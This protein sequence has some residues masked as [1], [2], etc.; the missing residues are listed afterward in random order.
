MISPKNGFYKSAIFSDESV[1]REFLGVRRNFEMVSKGNFI[2]V[3]MKNLNIALVHIFV[4]IFLIYTMVFRAE[5]GKGIF[6]S[7][8]TYATIFINIA[9]FYF[10]YFFVLPK[11]VKKPSLL[12]VLLGIFTSI[13]LFILLKFFIE[14][15]FL[16]KILNLKVEDKMGGFNWFFFYNLM[17]STM[18]ILFSSFIWFVVYAFRAE[19]EKQNLL[20]QKNEAEM[21]LLK[22]QINPHF[23]FNTLNNIYSL[24]NQKSDKS[25]MAIEKLG[26]LLRYSGKE[27]AQE[28]TALKNEISYIESLID[29]ESL[30]LTHPE[31]VVF[32]KKISDE[33]LEIAPMLLIPFVENAFK[34]GDLKN[35]KFL[36]KIKNEGNK[37]IL[38]QKNKIASSN[39]DQSTGIGIE[40]VRKRLDILYPEKHR[41]K[42]D[43]DGEFYSVNLEIDL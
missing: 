30:R 16:L 25:L 9:V 29:L 5:T 37:L 41:L 13:L 23:I 17:Q 4:W 28:K 7:A 15:F 31:N 6:E 11:I 10:N 1:C 8:L 34:H 2:F 22:S 27:I 3:G 18:P 12:K 33:N 24:V 39:K 36:I 40:N 32:E 14:E 19:K 20:Q 42:I 35:D 38:N 21:S 43:N 26:D